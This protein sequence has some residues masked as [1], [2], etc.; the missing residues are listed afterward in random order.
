MAKRKQQ[1]KVGDVFVIGLRDGTHAIGQIV[2]REAEVL[3]SVSVALFNQRVDRP[4]KAIDG[5][6]SESHAFSIL[7]AT[8][9]LLDSGVWQIV[10]TRPVEIAPSRFPFE[11]T[12]PAGFV[13]ARVIG[14]KIVGELAS[15][16]FGLV[17]WDDW[18]DPHYLDKLLVSPDRIPPNRILIKTVTAPGS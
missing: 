18:H 14:S 3:N 16:F 11:S 6:R 8:R 12:R 13:G 5:D 1:W 15:A 17:P 9:D 10:G 2:G 4:E 7:F